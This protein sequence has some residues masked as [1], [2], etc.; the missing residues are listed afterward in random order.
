MV[1]ETLPRA[2]TAPAARDAY[3]VDFGRSPNSGHGGLLERLLDSTSVPDD[4]EGPEWSMLS[5]S[6]PDP[7]NGNRA[8]TAAPYRCQASG[9]AV[10]RREHEALVDEF[11]DRIDGE[12]WR[13]QHRR[14]FLR[15]QRFET[16]GGAWTAF[17]TL[18]NGWR[19][20]LTTVNAGATQN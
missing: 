13:S 18:A 14:W 1:S 3:F 5:T 4:D 6:K 8:V 7:L 12:L 10:I 15:G 2:L 9:D 17:V 19:R 16:A 20:K 11:F